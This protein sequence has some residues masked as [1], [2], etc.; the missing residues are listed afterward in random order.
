VYPNLAGGLTLTGI[1]Q[2]WVSD[3]T[4]IRLDSEFVFLA[5]IL[6][7]FSRHVIG[8]ALDRTDDLTI[9]ALSIALAERNPALGLVHHSDRGVQYASSDYTNLLKAHRITIS[10][11][12]KG[13]PYDNA[14]CESFMKTLKYD[15]VHRQEYR[16][17]ADAR[18]SIGRFLEKIYNGKCL[19]HRR[20]HNGQS[21][22]G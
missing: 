2:L 16:D 7:A 17:L 9:A 8:W 3:I 10:V 22:P 4:C 1:N 13:N 19:D 15:E 21:C 5:V 14:F 12:R 20:S 6:D 11:S 18:A